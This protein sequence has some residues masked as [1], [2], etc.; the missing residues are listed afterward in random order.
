MSDDNL[1]PGQRKALTEAKRNREFF[2][3]KVWDIVGEVH[4]PPGQCYK[5]PFGKRARHG[6][7]LRERT[8]GEQIAV[9]YTLL[10]YIHKEHLGVSLPRGIDVQRRRPAG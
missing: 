5:N 4:L 6:W 9:G 10:R 3:D 2:A 1:T 7:I 8:T